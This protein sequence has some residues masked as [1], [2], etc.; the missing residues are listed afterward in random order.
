MTDGD[1]I[2]ITTNPDIVEMRS[3]ERSF[4][5]PE[6]IHSKKIEMEATVENFKNYVASHPDNLNYYINKIPLWIK[7]P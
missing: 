2:F 4:N 6:D 3:K 7:S 1:Q 5:I